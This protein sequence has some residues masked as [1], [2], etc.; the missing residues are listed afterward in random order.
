M[1]LD[2]CNHNSDDLLGK[3]SVEPVFLHTQSKFHSIPSFQVDRRAR[4]GH[5]S[6]PRLQRDLPFIEADPVT[7]L[8]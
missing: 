4:F 8:A 3:L 7:S 2:A 1:S 6:G 5:L